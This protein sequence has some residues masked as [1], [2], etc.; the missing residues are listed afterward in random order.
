MITGVY[1]GSVFSSVLSHPN[2]NL[3]RQMFEPSACHS[4]LIDH[5]IALRS[6]TDR[7]IALRQ[8][9]VK[10]FCVTVLFYLGNSGKNPSS[11]REGMLTPKPEESGGVRVGGRGRE[12]DPWP[13]GSSFYIFFPPI[14]SRGPALCKLGQPGVLLVLPEVLTPVLGP[15][16]V[17]F[18]RAFPFRIF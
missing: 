6:W 13:F 17:L 10:Q 16:F 9:S 7:V 1:Q 14:P 18:S 15:S 11:R 5:V 12:R 8:I 3:K 4:S 2:K